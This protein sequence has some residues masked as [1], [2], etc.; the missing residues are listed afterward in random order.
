MGVAQEALV[1]ELIE[2]REQRVVKSVDV[3]EPDGLLENL[4]LNPRGHLEGFLEGADAAGQHGEGAGERCHA[5]FTRMHGGLDVHLRQTLVAH[6]T[7]H[8][9]LRQ[10]AVDGRACEVGVNR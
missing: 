1:D 5:R 9:G 7:A 3:Q 2:K 8:E 6:L 4:E 10:H